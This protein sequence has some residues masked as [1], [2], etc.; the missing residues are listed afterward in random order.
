MAHHPEQVAGYRVISRLGTGGMGTVYLVENPPQ[1]RRRE[2]LKVISIAETVDEEFVR[3]FSREAQTAAALD[4]P[5]IVTI[6]HYGVTD[7]DPWF[8]MTY[9]DGQDLR[10]SSFRPDEILTVVDRVADALDYAHAHGVV[11]RDI[12]PGNILIAEGGRNAGLVKI[13]DFGISRAKDD[14]T[15]TQT[16]MIT[17]TPAYFA[18][19]VARGAEP[20]EPPTS[21]RWVPRSTRWSRASHRSAST[22]T[23]SRCCTRSPGR[24]SIR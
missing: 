7:D 4:H 3:R 2:A 15:L 12:K 14:V 17:G 6:Y 5:N 8:T 24:G 18:P 11:H 20:M 16:G 22:T 23:R 9:L 10:R 21:I 13:T 1:L 19:E